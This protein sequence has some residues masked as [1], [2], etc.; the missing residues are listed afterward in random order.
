MYYVLG[1]EIMNYAELRGIHSS[2][3]KAIQQAENLEQKKHPLCCQRYEAI[4]PTE[5]K[6]RK[7]YIYA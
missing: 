1:M 6:K 2:K 7:I 5:A 3:K 4:T